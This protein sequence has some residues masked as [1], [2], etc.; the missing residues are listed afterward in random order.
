MRFDVLGQGGIPATGVEAV[1]VN[2]TV[3]NPGAAGWAKVNRD[4]DSYASAAL[5]HYRSG[6]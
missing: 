6:E 2:L 3:W 4:D 1:V 5:L